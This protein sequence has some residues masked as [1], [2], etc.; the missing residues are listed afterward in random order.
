M[1][2]RVLPG[3]LIFSLKRTCR[4]YQCFHAFARMLS[5]NIL[6]LSLLLSEMPPPHAPIRSGSQRTAPQLVDL[7]AQKSARRTTAH[8]S[9]LLRTRAAR[10]PKPANTTIATAAAAAPPS[11]PCP[12]TPCPPCKASAS[13]LAPK[14]ARAAAARPAPPPRRSDWSP[15]MLCSPPP[16]ARSAPAVL[17]RRAMG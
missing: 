3:D 2:H 12:P 11:P 9:C 7:T 5:C 8:W 10:A 1:C 6:I 17:S 16:S 13:A 14:R 15:P 4:C